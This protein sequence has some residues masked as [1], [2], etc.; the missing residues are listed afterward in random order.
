MVPSE[1]EAYKC[2]NHKYVITELTWKP[3]LIPLEVINYPNMWLSST[4]TLSHDF[5][6]SHT[7]HQATDRSH[8]FLVLSAQK[9]SKGVAI[10]LASEKAAAQS[11]VTDLKARLACVTSEY[12]RRARACRK[13]EAAAAERIAVAEA[14]AA[15]AESRVEE[16]T[17]KLNRSEHY[18]REAEECAVV[19]VAA[20]QRARTGTHRSRGW[21]FDASDVEPSDRASEAKCG[22]SDVEMFPITARVFPERLR[23]QRL[24]RQQDGDDDG[25]ASVSMASRRGAKRGSTRQPHT[26]GCLDHG[27][28]IDEERQRQPVLRGGENMRQRAEGG[29]GEQ[30]D[31]RAETDAMCHTKDV[32]AL[33]TPPRKSSTR[34]QEAYVRG[35]AYASS[36]TVVAPLGENEAVD[37]RAADAEREATRLRIALDRATEEAMKAADEAAQDREQAMV[38]SE[39][40]FRE[41]ADMDKEVELTNANTHMVLMEKSEEKRRRE[42]GGGGRGG[43]RIEICDL[44][45]RGDITFFSFL[46]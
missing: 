28:W 2:W 32:G 18:L 15:E 24:V 6:S 10:S 30:S 42:G 3:I 44:Q 13:A 12:R 40:L 31:C 4:A 20:V 22:S 33:L 39:R 37:R 9:N 11:R 14:R 27:Q 35:N 5:A 17:R 36:T 41:L 45:F 46:P 23:G 38:E 26:V 34:R 43:G 19:A 29:Q 8:P 1:G 16:A 7:H 25:V 21:H